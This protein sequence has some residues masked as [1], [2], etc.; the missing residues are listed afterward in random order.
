[1]SEPS[2]PSSVV[3]A[4]LQDQLEVARL[5]HELQAGERQALELLAAGAPLDEVLEVIVTTIERVDPAAIA[6]L[7]V[8]GNKGSHFARCIAPS[9]PAAYNRVLAGQAIGFDVGSCGTAAARREPVF[10][11]D[12]E[13]DPLWAQY[14]EL[15]LPYGL[16]A[17]WS[18]PIFATDGRVLG[19]F[20]IYYR[21][22]RLPDDRE[23]ESRGSRSSAA[24]STISCASCRRGS[25][26]CARTSGPASRARSTTSSARR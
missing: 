18:V 12:I 10:V 19:T 25:R 24:S 15:V 8:L 7:L 9:L 3:I 2:R 4:A 6:S 5:P 23:R 26:R 1:M 14:R 21:E 11:G 22:P 16:R 20:A 13:T 17:C